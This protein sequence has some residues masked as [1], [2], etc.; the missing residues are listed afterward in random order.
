[1]RPFA[2]FRTTAFAAL[3]AAPFL[4][5]GQTA[6]AQNVVA[7]S[8]PTGYLLDGGACV[9][10]GPTPTCPSGYAF[11]AGKCVA[12]QKVS[13]ATAP[14]AGTKTGTMKASDK[15]AFVTREA[16]GVN[17][18]AE[19]DGANFCATDGDAADDAG[20][21]FRDKG[22][23]ATHVKVANS[24][25]GVAEYQKFNCDVLVVADRVA[26]S[27]ADSL[28]PLGGHLVLPEKF[29]KAPAA[30]VIKKV[31][32][33]TATPVPA[34]VEKPQAAEQPAPPPAAQKTP[35]PPAKAQPKPVQKQ[36]TKTAK[37]K[38]C[39]AVRYGYTSGNTCKCA[40]GRVFTGSQCVRPRWF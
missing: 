23:T 40:G 18:A 26:R 31:P 19:L 38:R 33:A 8:C 27:T 37:R 21:F 14:A 10:T 13:A 24:R 5:A 35:P 7:A 16:F 2:M 20:R 4:A 1:M 15:W 17:S 3:A 29:G 28:E 34:P 6:S 30:P 12:A 25:A 11:S 22:L 9:K 36:P 32:V 39:S